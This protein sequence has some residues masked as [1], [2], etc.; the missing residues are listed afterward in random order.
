MTVRDKTLL[1]LPILLED[2]D[3]AASTDSIIDAYTTE[4]LVVQESRKLEVLRAF[5]ERWRCAWLLK[6]PEGKNTPEGKNVLS[7]EEEEIL[8]LAEIEPLVELLPRRMEKLDFNDKSVR[9]LAHLL[10]PI[11]FLS[12]TMVADK[13][14][15][16]SDLALV[17]L[18]LDPYP[19][20]QNACRNGSG[21][22]RPP[23]VEDI[24]NK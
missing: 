13:Y 9:K 7:L 14:N 22:P 18:Y 19:E 24:M 20:Y 17:R 21:D 2:R 11:P 8:G 1:D 12:A 23:L 5:I 4:L 15:V 6:I 3:S 16:G 10:I